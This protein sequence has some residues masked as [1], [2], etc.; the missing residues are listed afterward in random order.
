MHLSSNTTADTLPWQLCPVQRL[1]TLASWPLFH[2][3]FLCLSSPQS[4]PMKQRNRHWQVGTKTY[5][6]PSKSVLL[7][8]SE[9]NSLVVALPL[10]NPWNGLTKWYNVLQPITTEEKTCFLSANQELLFCLFSRAW[11]W[12]HDSLPLASIICFLRLAPVTWFPASGT[13]LQDFPRLAP[14]VYFPRL[15]SIAWSSVFGTVCMISRVWHRLHGFPRLAP[16]AWFPAF[17]TGY[18][19]SRVWHR[20]HI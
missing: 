16:V 11:Y 4:L 3:V 20:P 12:L 13:V 9:A 7:W 17:G 6:T 8:L 14:I 1:P 5:M 10:P 2:L 19:I 15:A 18:M